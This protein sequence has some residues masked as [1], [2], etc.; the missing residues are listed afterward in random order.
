MATLS[1]PVYSSTWNEIIDGGGDAGDLFSS[2]QIPIGAGVLDSITG[3]SETD[4]DGDIYRILVSDPSSFV[5]TTTGGASHDT[6]LYLFD[7]QGH[8]WVAQDDDGSPQSTIFFGGGLDIPSPGAFFLAIT[9]FN[10]HIVDEAGVTFFD[11]PNFIMDFAASPI[12]GSDVILWQNTSWQFDHFEFLGG[13]GQGPYS[14]DLTGAQFVPILPTVWLFGSGLI[15][16]VA[17]RKKFKK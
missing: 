17:L 9:P 10:L 4:V 14:I 12:T 6:I 11:D 13:S 2:A 3:S 7:L 16:L 8:L 5:A 1:S 15:G